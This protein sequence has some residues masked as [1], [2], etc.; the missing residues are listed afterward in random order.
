MNQFDTFI[1][2]IIDAKQLPGLTEDSKAGLIEEM[3]ECLLDMIDRALL[4]ALPDEKVA[5]FSALADD[6]QVTNEQ[7]QAFITS[8]GVNVEEVTTTTLVA[9]RDLYLGNEAEQAA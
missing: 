9:F 3:R 7:L 2:D 5:E 4:E 8:N 1:S 6:S